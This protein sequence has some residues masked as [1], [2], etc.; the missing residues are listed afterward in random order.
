M[1]KPTVGELALAKYR[2]CLDSGRTFAVKQV[3][4]EVMIAIEHGECDEDPVRDRA[5]RAVEAVDD[6]HRKASDPDQPTLEFD[7][8]TFPAVLTLGGG[9]RRAA[10]A[11][12]LAD[13]MADFSIK[14]K[15]NADQNTAFALYNN[16]V[17]RL[18]PFLQQG[19]TL[20]EAIREGNK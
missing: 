13:V 17:T 2:A 15:N 16:R 14:A 6:K 18:L 8:F 4:D 7:G 5:R 19:M 1:R 10:G 12:E 11:A 3:V 20:G 9:E